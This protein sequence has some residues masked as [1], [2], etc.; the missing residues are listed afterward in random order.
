[1]VQRLFAYLAI[2]FLLL[3]C[4][5]TSRLSRQ[6]QEG[7]GDDFFRALA[8]GYN[9]LAQKEEG[10][11]DWSDAELFADKGLA[12]VRQRYVAAENP[13]DRE[14][15]DRFTLDE[16]VTA[17]NKISEVFVGDNR[18]NFPLKAAR[19]QILYD[20]WVEQAEEDWQNADIKR[21][22]TEF[23]QTY[24]A[25]RAAI[26]LAAAKERSK[27]KMTH[28]Y[29]SIYFDFNKSSLDKTAQV[30]LNQAI[31]HIKILDN[32][33]II[34]EGHTDLSGVE[35]VNY[36]LAKSRVDAVKKYLLQQGVKKKYFVRE[37]VFG[38]SKPKIAD[39]SAGYKERLNRRVEVYIIKVK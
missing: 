37:E 6:I 2:L 28:D 3:S 8:L 4:S 5:D 17:R 34:L 14:I 27:P 32:P 36:V 33:A 11:F 30:T 24:N 35:S 19:L 16:L 12:A 1:M 9:Q 21:Y 22:R 13:T 26:D 10:E 18:F 23:W 20:Y 31:N 29:Y 25:M 15:I 38:S 7:Q 39:K